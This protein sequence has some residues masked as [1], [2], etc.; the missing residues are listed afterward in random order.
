MGL[1]NPP[2]F[3]LNW[4]TI[5]RRCGQHLDEGVKIKG[6]RGVPNEYNDES[7]KEY[8]EEASHCW[9]F[10]HSKAVHVTEIN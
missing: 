8:R 4:R 7:K 10:N 5:S 2:V 3:P 9:P 1:P 6:G